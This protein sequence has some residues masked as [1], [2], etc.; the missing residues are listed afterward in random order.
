VCLHG[1]L[2]WVLGR[3]AFHPHRVSS[4]GKCSIPGETGTFV[5]DL[6]L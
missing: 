2:T 3:M 4:K 5:I 6:S 1:Q